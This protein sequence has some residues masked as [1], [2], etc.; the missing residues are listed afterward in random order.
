MAKQTRQKHEKSKANSKKQ[1]QTIIIAGIAVLLILI[2]IS[3]VY[4]YNQPQATVKNQTTNNIVTQPT[5]QNV[6]NQTQ[7]PITSTNV[8]V[9][10]VSNQTQPA[11]PKTITGFCYDGTPVGSCNTQGQYCNIGHTLVYDCLGDT[12]LGY[13]ACSC[14]S[15]LKCVTSGAQEGE[16][17]PA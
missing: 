13:P 7:P 4:Y 3:G 17:L 11:Q 8:T 16:C 12:T 1:N 9:S 5:V 10:N 6:S 15:G 2:I 14:G